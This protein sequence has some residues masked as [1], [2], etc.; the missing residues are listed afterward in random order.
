MVQETENK[1]TNDQ[2]AP[3]IEKSNVSIRAT[4]AR[5]FALILACFLN[6]GSYYCFDNPQALQKQIKDNFDIDNTS[7]GLL[8]SVYSFPNI[9]LPLIGGLLI[10]RI[11]VRVAIVIFSF[12]LIV[13]QGVFTLGAYSN[14]FPL[15]I[16]GRVIFGL[17]G[18][19]LTV[20]QSSV[21]AKWF[22][23]KE[24]AFS[25][26]ILLCVSRS[27]SSLNSALSPR[28]FHWFDNELWVPLFVG[29]CFCVASFFCGLWLCAIDR[30]ADQ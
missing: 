8:Y 16:T 5:W 12:L 7:F 3:L 24:L 13:G 22:I 17:G 21:T 30:K 1:D 20:S 6:F 28:F 10:D 26:G 25:M 18:E 23:G 14:S 9:I 2:D 15:M 29:F 4:K 27:G 11:G 19:S